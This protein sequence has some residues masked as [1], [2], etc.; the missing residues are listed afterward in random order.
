MRDFGQWFC[1]I[2]PE[3]RE[4]RPPGASGSNAYGPDVELFQPFTSFNVCS[5]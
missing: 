4:R 3:S 1:L 2:P 5:F